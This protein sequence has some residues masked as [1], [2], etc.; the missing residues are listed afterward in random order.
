MRNLHITIA[1]LTACMGISS[2]MYGVNQGI[3]KD[4]LGITTSKSCIV[5]QVWSDDNIV[6]SSYINIEATQ[7]QID[8]VKT[9]ADS[10]YKRI[11]KL[12]Q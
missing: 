7:H 12:K 4:C 6:W 11:S 1:L 5:T 10:I 2:C 9:K 3:D 8:S